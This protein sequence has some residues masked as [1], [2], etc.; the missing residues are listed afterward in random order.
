MVS[1]DDLCDRARALADGAV[2]DLGGERDRHIDTPSSYVPARFRSRV[3]FETTGTLLCGDL[4][5]T[6]ATSK[7]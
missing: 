7:H 2:I 3:L 1:L 5:P 6:P 4:S